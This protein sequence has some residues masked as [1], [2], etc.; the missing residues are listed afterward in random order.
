MMIFH[1]MVCHDCKERIYFHEDLR[2]EFG[3]EY[4]EIHRGHN[5]EWVNDSDGDPFQGEI[6]RYNEVHCRY[7]YIE[8]YKEIK[9]YKISSRKTYGLTTNTLAESKKILINQLLKQYDGITESALKMIENMDEECMPVMIKNVNVEFKY[10]YELDKSLQDLKHSEMI[11][12]FKNFTNCEK[13]S[14]IKM[15]KFRTPNSVYGEASCLVYDKD[16]FVNDAFE[17]GTEGM[18]LAK[19]PRVIK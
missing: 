8:I 6:A 7:K 14:N 16:L 4:E 11:K 19:R 10:V 18:C 12:V 3:Q 9:Q 5:F 15:D 13:C 1:W 17:F 2:R